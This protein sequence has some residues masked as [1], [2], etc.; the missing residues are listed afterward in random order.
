[1][2]LSASSKSIAGMRERKI[3]RTQRVYI[4]HYRSVSNWSMNPPR[5]GI[6]PQEMCTSLFPR[7][8]LSYSQQCITL[9]SK[10]KTL[11]YADV[12]HTRFPLPKKENTLS[13]RA[14]NV[15]CLSEYVPRAS[16]LSILIRRA[17]WCM[18]E[19]FRQ[20]QFFVKLGYVC[21]SMFS[22]YA[23]NIACLHTANNIIFSRHQTKTYC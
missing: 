9:S 15:L 10:R 12:Y 1:M 14:I 11:S 20:F 16:F 3:N 19:K 17:P 6:V 18:T 5:C 8:S 7:A 23:K 22:K 4:M 21:F 13:S 2:Q